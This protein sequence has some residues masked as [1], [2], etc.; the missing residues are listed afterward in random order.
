MSPPTGAHLAE[1][2]RLKQ[3]VAALEIEV[4]K[5][6]T[7][8][9]EAKRSAQPAYLDEDHKCF[10]QELRAAVT[11]WT[12]LFEPG[13]TRAGTTPKRQLE[14]WL[15]ETYNPQLPS[16][17][18]L[19]ENAIARVATVANPRKVGGAPRTPEKT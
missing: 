1:R 10:A 3:R 8:V 4:E 9:E 12:A 2:D 5:A 16:G 11:A 15:R 19:G 13:Q 6:K 7:E 18:R 17:E 14:Q